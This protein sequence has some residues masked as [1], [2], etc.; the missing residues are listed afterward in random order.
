MSLPSLQFIFSGGRS[1]RTL[2]GARLLYLCIC[3]VEK[4]WSRHHFTGLEAKSYDGKG[5]LLRMHEVV[6]STVPTLKQDKLGNLHVCHRATE[7]V[8]PSARI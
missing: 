4:V 8:N 7:Q 5:A 3:G 1:D 2:T 6:K